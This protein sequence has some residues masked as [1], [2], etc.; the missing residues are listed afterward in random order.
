MG[1]EKHWKSAPQKPNV[2]TLKHFP[3][4]RLNSQKCRK[5]PTTTFKG[6]RTYNY[7]L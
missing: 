7:S 6:E 4:N 2:T 1:L 5:P 3:E